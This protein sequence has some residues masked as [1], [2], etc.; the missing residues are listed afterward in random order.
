[1]TNTSIA[2]F[3]AHGRVGR[4]IAGIAKSRGLHVEILGWSQSGS[5][6]HGEEIS[7]RLARL[8]GRV[9]IIFAGGLTNPN[10]SQDDL[11]QANVSGPISVI[12]ATKTNTRYRY[13]TVG[14]IL[15]T[16]EPLVAGNRYLTS[17]SILWRQIRKLAS[18]T[19]LQGRIAHIRGHTFYG[20]VPAPHTFLGQLYESLARDKP[21]PMSDGRQLREYM[22]VQDVACSILA[23]LGNGCEQRVDY[24]LSTG[25]PVQLSTLASAVFKAFDRERLLRVGALATPQGENEIKRFPRAPDWLLG[26]SRPVIAGVTEWL[27]TLLNRKD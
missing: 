1:M 19:P 12:Q 7:T 18:E 23:L 21:F 6:D 2:L 15:E 20:G 17:K 10:L 26:K 13:L 11:I 5:D 16:I 24:D 27:K 9:D 14:S 4:A 25:E 8:N 22:H 3:G